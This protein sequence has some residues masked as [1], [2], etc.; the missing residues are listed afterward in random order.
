LTKA[1]VLRNNMF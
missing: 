1:N